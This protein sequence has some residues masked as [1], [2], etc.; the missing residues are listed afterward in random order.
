MRGL[1]T[2]LQAPLHLGSAMYAW[3]VGPTRRRSANDAW[4]A[5]RSVIY[6][7]TTL[8]GRQ[9]PVALVERAQRDR[10]G[11]ALRGGSARGHDRTTACDVAGDVDGAG[12]NGL[13][14]SLARY[15]DGADRGE[16]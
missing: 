14:P 12:G 9:R 1:R 11:K 8:R 6:A 7:G 10:A 16:Q 15:G 13:S 5:D 4:T 2:A 3:T